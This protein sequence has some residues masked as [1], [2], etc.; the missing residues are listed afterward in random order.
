MQEPIYRRPA[1]N[2]DEVDAFSRRWRRVHAWNHGRLTKI[3]TTARRRDRR[4]VAQ[5]LRAHAA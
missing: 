3:K 1:R 2:G 5:V 4:L